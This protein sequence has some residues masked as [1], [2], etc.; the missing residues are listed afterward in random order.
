MPAN[1]PLAFYRSSFR[2]HIASAHSRQSTAIASPRAE[3]RDRD[4]AHYFPARFLG[5][6]LYKH[7]VMSTYLHFIDVGQGNMTLIRLPNGQVLLYDCSVTNDNADYV[8]EYLGKYLR[9]GS[10]IDT[11]IN[12]HR[13][14]D[15]MRGISTIHEWY[16]IAHVWDSGVTGGTPN[17]TEY[18]EYMNLRR[19]VGYT[20]IEP[21]KYYD[22][23]IVRLRIF[24]SKNDDLSD[25]P[26]AQ[27][28]VIKVVHRHSAAGNDPASAMLTGDT[29][30]VT[31]K[32]I[33]RHYNDSDFSCSILLASHHGS[34]TFFDDPSNEKNYY[35]DHVRAMSPAMTILSVGKDNPHGH[36]DKKAIEL[37]SK[38]STGSSNG[39]KIKRTDIHG[40]LRLELK[41]DGGWSLNQD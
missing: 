26:N 41:D 24:N 39:N 35:T 5:D 28:I 25:N 38:Y 7:T 32:D 18:R 17:S 6:I 31:W 20:E 2:G 4:G 1:V 9:S 14:A 37:Y 21:R 33:R 11:F 40:S 29:D 36:P 22:K 27:S 16:P 13:D 8:L 10:K 19:E 12:S 30:A 34:V 3:G 23:G 15:H